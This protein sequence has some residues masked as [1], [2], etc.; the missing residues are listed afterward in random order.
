MARPIAFVT[1][2]SR[3]I[4]K[5]IALAL[6]REGHDIIVS[7]RTVTPGETRDNSL[8]VHKSDSRPL[9]GSLHAWA[10]ERFGSS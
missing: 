6:A 5:A 2:A 7:A 10:A 9:P 4:G 1:G 3:G 8:T